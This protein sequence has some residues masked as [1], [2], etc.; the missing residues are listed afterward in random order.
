MTKKTKEAIKA[1]L[2]IVLAVLAVILLWIYPLYESGKIV[3]RIE[4]SPEDSIID[5][6]AL[7]GDKMTIVT[8]DNI[9][10][11]GSYFKS[12]SARGTVIL[13]HGLFDGCVSQIAKANALHEVGF[14]V[15]LYDQRAYG[16]SKGEYRSGGYFEANDLQSVV[17]RL[18]LEDRLIRPT[19]VWGEDHGATAALRA[20]QQERRIEYLILENPVVNGRDW[21]ERVV[22][23]D[24]LSAPQLMLP[25]IWWW[26]KQKSGYEISIDETDITDAYAAL[27]ENKNGR[28]ISVSCGTEGIPENDHVA[29]LKALGGDWQILSCTEESDAGR[30][31]KVL[32]RL[33]EMVGQK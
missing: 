31:D 18:D 28:L 27:L 32:V 30:Y 4:I 23:H 17:S 9:D 26:M 15:V 16:E 8:E 6:P 13:L 11:N 7:P 12:D 21:Q 22:A 24:E 1:T 14:N 2:A 10:L 29:E 5:L 33:Q 20:S 3:S 25:L 19:I